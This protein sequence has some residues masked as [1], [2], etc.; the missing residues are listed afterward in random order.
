MNGSKAVPKVVTR[1]DRE[2]LLKLLEEARHTTSAEEQSIRKLRHCLEK[3][4]PVDSRKIKPFIVTMN[5]TFSLK[6]LGNGSKE[7]YRLVY[8]PDSDP[9]RN[10]ISV[11]S[12]IG[13]EALGTPEGTI[14]KTDSRGE[15]YYLIE[16]I[17]YQPEAAGNYT[18]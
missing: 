6:N 9:S 15:Q 12:H 13:S 5:S 17:I 16:E 8:P 18:L 4:K 10:N 11:L 7:T 14:I 3:I 2:K 1:N